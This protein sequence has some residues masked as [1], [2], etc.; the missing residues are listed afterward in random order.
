MGLLDKIRNFVNPDVEDDEIHNED[1][2]IGEEEEK[3]MDSQTFSRPQAA[4]RA[5]SGVNLGASTGNIE[6]KVVRPE[7]FENV[8]QVA[9]HLLNKRTVVLNLEATSKDVSRRILDFLT[10]V[11]YS[12]NGQMKKVA[13]NTYVITPSNVDV[14]GDPIKASPTPAPAPVATPA[15]APDTTPTADINYIR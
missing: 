7:R 3:E 9:E 8:T 1:I 12:I 11:A 14:S 13:N 15:P 2:I 4:P 5:A 6:L 10:G